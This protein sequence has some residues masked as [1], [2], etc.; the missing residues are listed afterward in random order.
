MNDNENTINSKSDYSFLKLLLLL[1]VIIIGEAACCMKDKVKSIS[2]FVSCY[3]Q[4]C[5]LFLSTFNPLKTDCKW[6]WEVCFF[7]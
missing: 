6:L 7:A 2:V 4:L 1:V 5:Y 3:T